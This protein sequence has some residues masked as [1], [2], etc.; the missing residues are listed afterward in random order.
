M[1]SSDLTFLESAFRSF[2]ETS[3]HRVAYSG[4]MVYRYR[5]TASDV[6]DATG[7]QRLHGTIIQEYEQFFLQQ[8]VQAA[9]DETFAAFNV[10]IDL[11]RAVLSPN[12]AKFLS[13]AM[14][15]YRAEH[16]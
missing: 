11:S 15:T 7:R 2:I 5:I 4:D 14:G 12:Q 3:I 13:T 1:Q 16:G 8:G 10:V 9:Y 6:K